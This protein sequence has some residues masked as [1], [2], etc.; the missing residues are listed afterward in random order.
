MNKSNHPTILY[1]LI[2]LLVIAAAIGPIYNAFSDDTHEHAFDY[3]DISDMGDGEIEIIYRY[4]PEC[5]ICQN[6]APDVDDFEDENADEIP[7]HRVHSDHEENRPQDVESGVPSV[8]VVEDGEIVD[9]FAGGEEVP[10]F[11]DDVLDDS[12]STD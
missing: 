12:Y 8:L 5:G 6:I 1:V 11:F 4:H 10:Q 7:F 3:R 2:G 9:E